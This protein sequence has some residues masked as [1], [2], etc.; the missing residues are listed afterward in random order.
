MIRLKASKYRVSS[1]GGGSGGG[2]KET[3]SPVIN[4]SVDRN[5]INLNIVLHGEEE[6]EFSTVDGESLI[7][8]GV[9]HNH[10]INHIIKLILFHVLSNTTVQK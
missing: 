3:S 1:S 7:G 9:I 2:I 5:K 4:K 10:Q 6:P 8:V